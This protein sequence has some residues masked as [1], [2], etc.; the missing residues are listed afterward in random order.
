[1]A[2]L[3]LYP[4]TRGHSLIIPIRHFES[5][6]DTP[7]HL[8]KRIV[9]VAKELS[10]SYERTL[11]IQGVCI[12]VLNHK[13][14]SPAFRHFHMAVIPRYDK[15]NKR[16]PANVKPNQR[17]PKESDRS[18]DGTLTKIKSDRMLLGNS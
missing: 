9:T 10:I 11:G 18:L 8:L 5:V 15:R 3:D 1:M 13:K 17:F 12:N 4:Y 16:D 2:I 7:E 6:F 14:K